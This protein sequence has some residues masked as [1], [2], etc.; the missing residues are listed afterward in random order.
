MATQCKIWC[1]GAVTVILGIS[2]AAAWYVLRQRTQPAPTP[3][4]A[5][6]DPHADAAVLLTSAASRLHQEALAHFHGDPKNGYARMPFVYEKIAMEWKTPWFSTGEL[7]RD[8]PVP[9]AKDMERLHAAARQD[10]LAPPEPAAAQPDGVEGLPPVLIW[11]P[12]KFDANKKVWEV[13]N[14]DLIGLLKQPTPVAYV[15]ERTTR[16]TG[17]DEPPL[18]VSRHI[19]EFE[20]AALTALQKGEELFGRSRDGV[21][22]LVG[23]VR[24]EESCLSCHRD[25]EEGDL[26]GAFSYVLREA[27]YQRLPWPGRNK[28]NPGRASTVQQQ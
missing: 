11:D 22:R 7:D 25:K 21:V 26:L 1:A 9:F 3:A 16:Q 14:I 13:K 15:S 27:S 12:K 18:P 5:P 8:E 2:V 20:L 19:D 4:G 23:A 17:E 28:G 6:E 10:F 24:A